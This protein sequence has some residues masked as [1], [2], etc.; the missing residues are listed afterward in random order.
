MCTITVVSLLAGFLAGAV[1]AITPATPPQFE[2]LF[3]GFLDV[4]LTHVGTIDNSTFGTRV[5]APITGCVNQPCW[6]TWH[7]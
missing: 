5:Y 3:V 4:D 6:R 2:T 1:Q 7:S